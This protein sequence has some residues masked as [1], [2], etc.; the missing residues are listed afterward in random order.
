MNNMK[1]YNKHNREK[2]I[3]MKKNKRKNDFNFKLPHNLRVRTRQ[4][5]KSQKFEK[6]IKTFGLI[7]RI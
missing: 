3:F 4:A 5:L 1:N 6:L 2:K 7:F